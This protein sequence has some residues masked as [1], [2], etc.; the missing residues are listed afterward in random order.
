MA[1]DLFATINS[2]PHSSSFLPSR[3]LVVTLIAATRLSILTFLFVYACASQ[4]VHAFNLSSALTHCQL[5]WSANWVGNAL[6]QIA[7]FALS[8]H[9]PSFL[10][11]RP[12]PSFEHAHLLGGSWHLSCRRWSLCTPARP[13]LTL[14]VSLHAE[15]HRCRASSELPHAG[16]GHADAPRLRRHALR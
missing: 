6:T 1:P 14:R 3:L 2:S 4:L 16:Y 7:V 11:S 9:A 8:S 12:S 13:Q 15:P 10:P 5:S